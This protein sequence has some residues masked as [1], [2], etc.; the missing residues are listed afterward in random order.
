M[1]C[2]YVGLNEKDRRLYAGLEAL[3]CGRGGRAYIAEV[4]GCSRNTVSKERSTRSERF[5]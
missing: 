2:F 3:K 1:R 5:I 4:I